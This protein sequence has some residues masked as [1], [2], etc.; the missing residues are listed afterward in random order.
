M[1]KDYTF[2]KKKKKKKRHFEGE[3]DQFVSP[4]DLNRKTDK[5]VMSPKEIYFEANLIESYSD[6]KFQDIREM[7]QNFV[8]MLEKEPLK[9]IVFSGKI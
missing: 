2:V 7:A 9:I 5:S 1:R 8:R 3:N 4:Q 6:A